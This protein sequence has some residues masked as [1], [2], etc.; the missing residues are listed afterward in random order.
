MTVFSH[1]YYNHCYHLII[2]SSEKHWFFVKKTLQYIFLFFESSFLTKM[3]SS[4]VLDNLDFWFVDDPIST[5]INF[6][7]ETLVSKGIF[8]HFLLGEKNEHALLNMFFF[9]HRCSL[10]S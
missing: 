9:P 5:K 2:F 4:H 3:F 8:H 7:V 6:L 10:H 1:Y